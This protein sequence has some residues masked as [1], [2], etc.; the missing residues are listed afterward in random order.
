[1]GYSTYSYTTLTQLLGET[2]IEL[3]IFNSTTEDIRIRR[4]LIEAAKQMRTLYNYVEKTET[5]EICNFQAELPC[6]FVRFDR[7]CPIAF[8]TNGQVSP[9]STS[10]V[11]FIP[12]Y[13]GSSFLYCSPYDDL[14][15]GSPWPIPT[16]QVQDG[17]L[18]FSSNISYDEC[19]IS[20]LAVNLGKDGCLRI[21]ESHS[22]ALI[23]YA[24]YKYHRSESG[25]MDVIADYKAEWVNQLRYQRAIAIIPDTLEQQ[26]IGY[27][28]NS[29]LN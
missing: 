25:R 12:I 20:Y 6:D 3:E 2:K 23:A 26:R 7:S 4:W 24:C 1:M 15:N 9:N 21:P 27:I 13:T 28:M 19:T 5:L 22:R 18:F 8:T 10:L 14:V 16:V 17:K 29:I 11:S